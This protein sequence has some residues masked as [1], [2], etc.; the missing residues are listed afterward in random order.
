MLERDA[1]ILAESELKAKLDVKRRA[2][3]RKLDIDGEKNLPVISPAA[4]T[5]GF[6]IAR[7]RPVNDCLGKIARAAPIET[8]RDPGLAGAP[9][10][11][12]PSRRERDM[13]PDPAGFLPFCPGAA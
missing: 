8:R 9:P 4:H 5:E 13:K 10:V 7:A 11:G 12:F 3:R 6:E 2:R 1:D